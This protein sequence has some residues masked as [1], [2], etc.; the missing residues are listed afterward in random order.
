MLYCIIIV[1]YKN[2]RGEN[3][4]M[5][6]NEK[7]ILLK[8]LAEKFLKQQE[9]KNLLSEDFDDEPILHEQQKKIELEV[10]KNHT[11]VAGEKIITPNGKNKSIVM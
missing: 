1:G 3:R 5:S 4:P 2:F 8:N 7:R 10:Y 9:A 11:K 6:K